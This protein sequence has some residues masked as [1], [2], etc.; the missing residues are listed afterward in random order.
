MKKLLFLAVLGTLVLTGSVNAE[1]NGIFEPFPPAEIMESYYVNNKE[2]IICL[3]FPKTLSLR[4]VDVEVK[5][6][7]ISENEFSWTLVGENP[8]SL[9]AGVYKLKITE[10]SPFLRRIISGFDLS[11]TIVSPL[12]GWIDKAPIRNKDFKLFQRD[13][14]QVAIPEGVIY[15]LAKT[16]HFK[17]FGASEAIFIIESEDDF[18]DKYEVSHIIFPD[19]DGF[20]NQVTPREVC[21][22][23]NAFLGENLFGVI[24]KKK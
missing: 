1:S 9:D 20:I 6:L 8:G 16:K 23:D 12:S 24:L 15:L 2:M 14:E 7:V 21:I 3:P 4:F 13:G 10:N 5:K 11:G 22:S 18:R 17:K 19:K